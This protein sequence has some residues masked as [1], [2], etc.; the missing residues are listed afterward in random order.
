MNLQTIKRI[1]LIAFCNI[2]FI[3]KVNFRRDAKLPDVYDHLTC[4]RYFN[5]CRSSFNS[6]KI[7]QRTKSSV[8]H[9]VG[10]MWNFYDDAV[11]VKLH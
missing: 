7:L 5:L 8:R 1:F 6:G 4:I 3:R 11:A 9:R 2:L 10:T